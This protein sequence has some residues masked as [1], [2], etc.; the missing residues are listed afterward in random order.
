[1]RATG[2]RGGGEFVTAGRGWAVSWDL[3]ATRGLLWGDFATVGWGLRPVDGGGSY[4]RGAAL[5][6]NEW[7]FVPL[8]ENKLN[9]FSF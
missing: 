1:M 5:G 8:T 6:G 4:N 9:P 7:L 2:V 3:V